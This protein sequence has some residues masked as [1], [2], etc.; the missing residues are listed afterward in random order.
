MKKGYYK[1]IGKGGNWHFVLVAPNH[2][3]IMTSEI[4]KS[5]QKAEKGIASVQ[6]NSQD[7]GRFERRNSIVGEPY[8]NLLAGNGE[9]IGTSEMYS[10]KQSRDGGINAV[11]LYGANAFIIVRNL[12]KFLHWIEEVKDL[13]ALR[14]IY[15]SGNAAG[16]EQTL[17]KPADIRDLFNKSNME[18]Y[19][20]EGMMPKDAI[21]EEL[22]VWS[23][24][25][26][27]NV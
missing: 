21:D 6:N 27:T 16:D 24:N 3:I 15:A 14:P 8:F 7:P 9:V 20:D 26:K 10:S 19:F 13:A 2:E 17:L 11:T 1:L 25:S 23:E 4:Y 18:T 22:N 5:Q 12:N